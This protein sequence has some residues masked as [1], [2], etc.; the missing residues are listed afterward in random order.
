MLR[1]F[2]LTIPAVVHLRDKISNS[3]MEELEAL[4]AVYQEVEKGEPN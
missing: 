4:S 3:L 2:A 1:P